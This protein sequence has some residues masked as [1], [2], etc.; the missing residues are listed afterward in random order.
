MMTLESGAIMGFSRKQK[1]NGKSSTEVELIGVDDVLPQIL[2]TRYFMKVNIIKLRDNIL[3]QDNK[4]AML[5]EKKGEYSVQK[6][7]NISM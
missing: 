4:N 7:P 1:A 2:W 5:L 3:F 6:E